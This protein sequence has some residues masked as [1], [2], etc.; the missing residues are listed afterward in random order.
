[1]LVVG[2]ASK[3]GGSGIC[4]LVSATNQ[5]ETLVMAIEDP[6]RLLVPSLKDLAGFAPDLTALGSVDHFE[7]YDIKPVKVEYG[8]LFAVKDQFTE[9]NNPDTRHF[10]VN[11]PKFLCNP[12]DKNEEG[13]NSATGT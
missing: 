10:T 2:G 3:D 11:K 13:I 5:F 7:C 1:M 8:Q 4:P 9:L 12:V 6:K